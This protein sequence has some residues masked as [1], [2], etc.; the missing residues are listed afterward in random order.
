MV[1]FL[2]HVTT[3]METRFGP[4]HL[5]KIKLL[6]LTPSIAAISSHAPEMATTTAEIL[7]QE[8]STFTEVVYAHTN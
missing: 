6:A 1:P 3:E 7:T 2:D 4:V 5:T 8:D